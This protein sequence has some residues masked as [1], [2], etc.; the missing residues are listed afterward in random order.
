MGKKKLSR[1][2]TGCVTSKHF[3]YC[4]Q[5][6]MLQWCFLRTW[7][8]LWRR[9]LV[10]IGWFCTI[11]S[12]FNK[13]WLCHSQKNMSCL[14]HPNRTLLWV[15]N[16]LIN[17]NHKINLG[18]TLDQ[19]IARVLPSLNFTPSFC[20][21]RINFSFSTRSS[22]LNGG[23][24]SWMTSLLCKISWNA[25]ETYSSKVFIS[26]CHWKPERGN[27][28]NSPKSKVCLL[29]AEKTIVWAND[30][31]QFSILRKT[32]SHG[33]V[34]LLT[35]TSARWRSLSQACNLHQF[36]ARSSYPSSL[37]GK[38]ISQST[39]LSSIFARGSHPAI[40]A[41]YLHLFLQVH[42]ILPQ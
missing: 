23:S 26:C 13:I 2:D 40:L 6:D 28:H 24:L 15:L 30:P 9:S 37:Y 1:N 22:S 16:F 14:C 27:F 35:S 34:T 17:L 12:L 41:R 7:K 20:T 8:G 38:I 42:H 18:Q 21:V 29:M 10:C 5:P 4:L 19:R 3:L 31:H 33:K 11:F 39:S 32:K 25:Q 36:F